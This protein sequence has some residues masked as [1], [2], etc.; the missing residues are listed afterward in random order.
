MEKMTIEPQTWIIT[1]GGVPSYSIYRLLK[2][3]VSIHS[4]G[5]K[6]NEIDVAEGGEPAY[7]GVIAALRS[8]RQNTASVRSETQIEV[9]KQSID[10]LWGILHNELSGDTQ[11]SVST[12]IEAIAI[13]NEIDSLASKL[14]K[15][16]GVELTVQD[17]LRSEAKDTLKEVERIYKSLV[18]NK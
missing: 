12:M 9:E 14:A 4:G 8:D 2:G 18:L 6:I 13:K 11:T 16:G 1:E 3:K 10:Q 7:L 17:D 15:L 5:V